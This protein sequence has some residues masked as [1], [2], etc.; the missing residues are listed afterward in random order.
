[1]SNARE[2]IT[3]GYPTPRISSKKHGCLSFFPALYSVLDIL[4]KHSFS[5]LIYYMIIGVTR[6]FSNSLLGVGYPYETLSLVFDILHDNLSYAS[7]FNSLL[8]VGYP[9]ETLSLVSDILHGNWRHASFFNS[10]LGVGNR[11][12]TLSL[13][14]DILLDN[15]SYASFF[16]LSSWCWI[17]W[18][19][20]FSRVWYIKWLL[21][22]HIVFQLTS[23]CWISRWNT[24]SRLYYLKSFPF[25]HCV[26]LLFQFPSSLQLASLATTQAPPLFVLRGN[27][28]LLMTLISGAFTEDTGFITSQLKLLGL[29]C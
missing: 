25:F 10:L 19:N 23:R 7:L 2:S 20:N 22:L 26:L 13:A 4:M 28:F 8:C 18:W 24:L 29:Q 17:S 11:D 6:R 21:G 12:E 16:Q 3:S 15:W 1:M 27:Q 9:D 5:C 14:F